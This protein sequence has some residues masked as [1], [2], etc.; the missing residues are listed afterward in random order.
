VLTIGVFDGLPRGQRR[1]E[2][3]AGK[4][5]APAECR[6]VM[7]STRTDGSG[8]PAAPRSVDG[9]DP[10]VPSWPRSSASTC[11]GDAF[12]TDFLKLTPDR[13]VNRNCLSENLH[14]VEVVV[15]K[16]FTF[17]KKA[18]GPV[19]TLRRAGARARGSRWIDV[20]ACRAPRTPRPCLFVDSLH[21]RSC[22]DGR[23]RSVV[24]PDRR[25][26]AAG[27]KPLW[28]RGGAAATAGTGDGF[29]PPRG[30]RRCNRPSGR[31][32]TR[33]GCTLLGHGR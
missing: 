30:P 10:G 11:S 31:G 15:V 16:N 29:P 22:V 19:D 12:T 20:T 5:A 4:S 25:S 13:Y 23:G 18:G 28:K 8:L 21:C 33:P 32:F 14:V 17:G 3:H 24:A 6:R 7:S 2:A 26:V 27:P 1:A 9:R